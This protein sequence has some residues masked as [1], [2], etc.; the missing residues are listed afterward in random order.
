M[1]DFVN[2]KWFWNLE[3]SADNSKKKKKSGKYTL[4]MSNGETFGSKKFASVMT[5]GNDIKEMFAFA[6]EQLKSKKWLL[7]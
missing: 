4:Y 5:D 3:H 6:V 1:F 2:D 7:M